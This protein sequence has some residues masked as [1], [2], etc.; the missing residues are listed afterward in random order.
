M[1]YPLSESD[2]SNIRDAVAEAE[3]R[4]SGEIVPFVAL[5]SS[6]YEIAV[7]RAAAVL[8]LASCGLVIL[9]EF[10]YQGW[11]LA[12]LQT[13][14]NQALLVTIAG[15][16]GA[17]I[18]AFVPAAKRLFAGR[19]RMAEGVRRRAMEAFVDK[20]VFATRDRTG[21]LLFVSLFERRIEV[22][23]DSGI[24]QKVSRSD[25]AAIVDRI[26]EGIKAGKLAEGLVS[27]IGMSGALL[28]QSGVEIRP[29]D[30]NELA[31]DVSFG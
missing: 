28:Q 9:L 24:N 2:L 18:A 6:N 26:R 29:D 23:G 25:W 22:L 1:K 12:W 10:V 19:A 31:D 11:R 8:A 15:A 4:T 16:S 17:L 14:V 21:I 13:P 30:T 20:E 7:W 5:R 3:G 27:G